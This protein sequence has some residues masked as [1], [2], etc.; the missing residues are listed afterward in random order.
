M[1]CP[2]CGKESADGAA[3][4]K[5]CGYDFSSDNIMNTLDTDEKN[6]KRGGGKMAEENK[7]PKTEKSKKNSLQIKIAAIVIAIV[8]VC[9]AAFVLISMFSASEGEKVLADVPI[10]RDVAYAETKTG[11]N[12]V[13]VSRYDAL[14][15]ISTFDHVCESEGGL[16]VEG[17][18]LPEWAI[19][20]SV[21]SDKTINRVAY[22]D[23]SVLQKT[24]K[25]YHASAEISSSEIIYG[26]SEKEVER[27]L[28]FEPYTI[29]K[30]IDNTTT[31]VY[32]YYYSD[33][34]TGDDVVCNYHVVFNDIDGNVKNVYNAELN[35]ETVIMSTN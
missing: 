23:F 13:N 33:D 18:N 28:G 29:I 27:K 26:M 21:G 2:K 5:N 7:A 4:C 14:V 25:G 22:Y 15:K 11:R 19:A 34:L 10:G 8:A 3:F 31:Y 30:E 35:Y 24:W 16:K 6:T 12:F 1:I 17:I 32:R 9:A 20:I